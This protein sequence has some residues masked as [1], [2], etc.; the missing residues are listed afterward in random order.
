MNSHNI[1]MIEQSLDKLE[2]V[3]ETQLSERLSTFFNNVCNALELT[4]DSQDDRDARDTCDVLFRRRNSLRKKNF[5]AVCLLRLLC[6]NDAAVW[7]HTRFSTETFKLF[8]HQINSIYSRCN[9]AQG[10]Q[11]HEKLT[12]LLGTEK[13][14]LANFQDITDSV[15]SLDSIP[16]ARKNLMSTLNSDFN[17][18]FLEQFVTPSSLVNR[19]LIDH[20]LDMAQTYQRSSMEDRI[21]IFGDLKNVFDSFLRN[22]GNHPSIFTKHCIV[23]PLEKIYNYVQE[24]FKSNDANKSTTIEIILLDR[25]YPFYEK[26]RDLNLKFRAVNTGPGYAFDL[27]IE[28]IGSK[29]LA[30]CIPVNLGTL[31]PNQ[32]SEVVFPTATEIGTEKDPMV[33]VKWSWW[34]FDRSESKTEEDIFGLQPQRNDL[35]WEKL[36][37]T[38]PY[39]LEPIERSEDMVGRDTLISRLRRRLLAPAIESSIIYGQKRVGKT[40]IA[41]FIESDIGPRENYTVILI[42]IGG[43]DKTTSERFVS[44]LGDTIVEEVSYKCE[45]LVDMKPEFES[46]LSPLRKYFRDASKRLPNHRFVI[47]LDEFD[48]IPL[49]MVRL[50]SAI[51]DTFFHNIRDISS[52]GNVGFILVGGENMHIIQQSTDRLNRMGVLQVDYF[53]KERYWDD[54]RELVKRPVQQDSIEFNDEAINTLYETTEGNPFYTK[55]I[56]R[57][58]YEQACDDRNAYISEDNVKQAIAT[59]ELNLNSFNHLWKDGIF[60]DDPAKKDQIETQRRKFLSWFGQINRKKTPVSIQDLQDMKGL[61]NE[62]A[63]KQIVDSYMNRG[64]LVRIE[65]TEFCRLKPKIFE[66]WLRDTGSTMMT[67]SA[68]DESAISELDKKE[69]EAYVKDTEIVD[70]CQRRWIFNG[71]EI[72]EVRVRAWLNQFKNNIQQRLMFRLLQK[73]NFYNEGRIQQSISNLHRRVQEYIAQK[74]VGRLVDGRTRRGDILLSSFGTPAKSGPSYARRYANVNKIYGA[75]VAF[76]NEIPEKLTNNSQIEAIVFVDDIIGSGLT[77]ITHFDNLNSKH[78]AL[79]KEKQIKVFVTAICGLDTGVEKVREAIKK[80]PFAVEV[81]VSDDLA[82]SDQC[83][84][85]ESEVFPSPKDRETA[86]DI[87]FQIGKKLE[88]KNPLGYQDNQLLAVFADNCPNNTLPILRKKSTKNITWMPLFER[89]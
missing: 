67:T 5:I 15:V 47:I 12:K 53:D 45:V 55:I 17:M 18:L 16:S 78:G 21:G 46:S 50:S 89:R 13:T 41:K 34:N 35:E 22:V 2:T 75:N 7:N 69:Q 30:P 10:D 8:D 40:S 87:A 64:V 3:D 14:V 6:R 57:T 86:K 27:H 31:R 4:Y 54:F 77:A 79:L 74:G 48:E 56:C 88:K 72:N 52:L 25:K 58:I 9:I 85:D 66:D 62:V 23:A 11:N 20:I 65:N 38:Q 24:D 49:D 26:N 68:L 71:S 36:K 19:E 61:K 33:D 28:C 73:V 51:G 60:V 37:L 1:Y 39:S 83:F 32:S 59:A 29:G 76:L 70:L 43:L 84:S 42:S 81:V 80:A 82:K 63:V 44:T